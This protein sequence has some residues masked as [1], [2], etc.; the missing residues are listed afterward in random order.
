[1]IAEIS[2]GAGAEFVRQ[3]RQDRLRR[4]EIDEG[5][6]A[7]EARGDG[8]DR[9]VGRAWQ[10]CGAGDSS[11]NALA[12]ARAFS[13]WRRYAS[14]RIARRAH[15]RE[16]VLRRAG[17]VDLRPVTRRRGRSAPAARATSASASDASP[18]RRAD[19]RDAGRE[20][21]GEEQ[22]V[23]RHAAGARLLRWP[24]APSGAREHRI[25]DGR[26]AGR[27]H[28]ARL[29]GERRIDARGDLGRCRPPP[30]AARFRRRRTAP[31]A[32][33]R[34]AAPPRRARAA[35]RAPARAPAP[36]CRCRT[37]RRPR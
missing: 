13:A 19:A 18:V 11:A 7:G 35:R 20:V 31:C 32:R 5:A 25:D 14:G 27:E 10:S 26:M 1:M 16:R 29:V 12:Y 37:S 24:R 21:G 33:R 6:E 30:A 9:I 22:A 8:D 36:T 4:I 17:G 15:A 2:R 23:E 28:A 3:Q 34:C